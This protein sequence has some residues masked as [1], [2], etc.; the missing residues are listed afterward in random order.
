MEDRSGEL[1]EIVATTMKFKIHIFPT[2]LSGFKILNF[3][4]LLG[5]PLRTNPGGARTPP[6]RRPNAGWG[7]PDF[8]T[9]VIRLSY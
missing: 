9:L 7:W 2:W 1:H 4:E 6:E 3:C 5:I 8:A